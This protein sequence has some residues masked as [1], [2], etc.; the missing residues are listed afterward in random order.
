MRVTLTV[1]PQGQIGCLYTEAID[2][3]AL[4]KLEIKRATNIEFNHN[5][6]QWEVHDISGKVLYGHR[7]RNTCLRW[8][9]KHFNQ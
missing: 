6:Q 2:L 4:G 8:E 7:S 9:Q 5:T 1:N 3:A